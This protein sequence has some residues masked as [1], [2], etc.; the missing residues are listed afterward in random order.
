M[1]RVWMIAVLAVLGLAAWA[2]TQIP[3]LNWTPRSDWSNVKTAF[4]AVG[5]GVADDT[6]ALQKAANSIVSGTVLYF[7]AGTYRITDTLAIHLKQRPTGVMV[8]GHGRDTKLVWDG[9]EGKPL[10]A[11]SGITHGRYEGFLLDGRGK[12]TVGIYHDA[13]VFETEVGHRHMAFLNFT[14]AGILTEKNPATAEVIIENCLFDHC[15]RGI[16]FLAFNDYDY[17]IDGCE[18]RDCE[19]AIQCSHGNTYVRNTHFSGSTN[20]DIWLNP[21]HGSTVRRCTSQGS[22]SFVTF[23]NS[24]APLTVQDCQVGGWT[25]PDGAVLIGGAP[26]AIFDCVFTTPPNQKPPINIRNGNQRL[27]LSQNVSKDTEGIIN[28]G[29]GKVYEIP[30]GKQHGSL[31]SP[32]QTFLRDTAVIPG[33]IFDVKKD[34]GAKGDGNSDDTAL[35]QTAIDAAAKQGH[36][37]IAYLPTGRYAISQP[38]RVT[39][40]DY[41]VGGTGFNTGLLWKGGAPG[42]NMIEVKDAKRVTLQHLSVGN[43]DV[44]SGMTNGCDI[45][46]T[47]GGSVTYDNVSV[48]GMYQRQPFVKGLWLRDLAKDAVVNVLHVQGNIHLV[49]AARG[50]V[51][52]GNSYEGSVVVEGKKKERDGFLGIITRLGTS[53]TYGLY[54]K[55]NHSLVASDYYIEQADNAYSLQGSPDDPPGRLTLQA[56]K[57]HIGTKPE[58]TQNMAFNIDGYHGQLCYGPAQFYIEPQQMKFRHT[59]TKPLNVIFWADSFYNCA[60]TVQKEEAAT[61][62]LVGCRGIN[63]NLDGVQVE[64]TPSPDTLAKLATALDDERL[65][66]ALDL[67]LNH[68]GVKTR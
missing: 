33:Q 40:A 24:V 13:G 26:V 28:A 10:I 25:N 54:V 53:C 22:K 29:V 45:L 36:G 42:G 8:I 3:A 21:E 47:G 23:V 31:R 48:F 55:D 20:T 18:F 43:H 19:T 15:K 56:P 65:L 57:L 44:G 62:S 14:D 27:F 60:L 61:I 68:P 52:L 32:D 41:Y 49:D 63:S 35:I 17:T 6:A 16:A 12:A 64:E 9:P 51:L 50:T 66:G 59:G 38:L 30:A 67:R 46:Q 1:V 7:P 5:D 34:F 2:G 4:G 39:G 11:E 58:P 37:A